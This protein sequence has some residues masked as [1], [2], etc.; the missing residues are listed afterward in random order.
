MPFGE[1]TEKVAP[2]EILKIHLSKR[3]LKIY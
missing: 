3:E 2:S 1:G